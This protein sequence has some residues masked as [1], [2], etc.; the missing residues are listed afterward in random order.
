MGSMSVMIGCLDDSGPQYP[1]CFV[2]NYVERGK[3]CGIQIEN[4]ADREQFFNSLKYIHKSAQTWLINSS[5]LK[6]Y[7]IVYRTELL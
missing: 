3:V 6:W 1:K 4:F 2:V 5:F 7:L